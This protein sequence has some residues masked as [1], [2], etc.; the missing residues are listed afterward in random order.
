MANPE[1]SYGRIKTEKF[2]VNTFSRFPKIL[3]KELNDTKQNSRSYKYNIFAVIDVHWGSFLGL[4]SSEKL[5]YSTTSTTFFRDLH[6]LKD[7]SLLL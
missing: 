2:S 1:T 5:F 4:S 3:M 7:I 6:L